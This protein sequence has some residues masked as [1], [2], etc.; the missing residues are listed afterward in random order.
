M[1]SLTE[2][3]GAGTIA[4]YSFWALFVRAHLFVQAV[5]VVLV[6]FSVWSWAVMIEKFRSYR[7]VRRSIAAFEEAFWSGGELESLYERVRVAPQSPIERVFISGM[8]E[9]TR[10]FGSGGKP[11]VGSPARIERALH[12]EVAR[13]VDMLRE[14]L[15]VLATVGSISPFI[16]L[17]GTVWGI[18]NSFESIALSQNTN[19]AIVAP[20]IAEAL[21]ATAL[22]L[23]AAIPAVIGYNRFQSEA[24]RIGAR[25]E[26]F[27]DEFTTLL[28][29]QI[30]AQV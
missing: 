10:S 27:A 21:V 13:E 8:A 30:A 9:W 18:K 28:S 5:I 23:L 14:R 1:E 4:D 19:L 24:E 6:V 20:G 2:L 25:F 26:A 16:G 11:L 22:G 3:A 29:R 15:G 7:H 12:V 17:F